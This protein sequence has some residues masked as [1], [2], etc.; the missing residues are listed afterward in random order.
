MKIVFEIFGAFAAPV[1][2]IY[3]ED[4]DIGPVLY[5]GEFIY[6]VDY[7][8]DDGDSIFIVLSY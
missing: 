8:Q 5:R 7:I 3:A 1:A 4:L 6:W 2:I